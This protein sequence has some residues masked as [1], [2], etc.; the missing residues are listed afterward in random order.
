MPRRV[1]SLVTVSLLLVGLLGF[2]V[3]AQAKESAPSPAPAVSEPAQAGT[4]GAEDK[5]EAAKGPD[6][7]QVEEQVGEQAGEQTEEGS[8]DAAL[9]QAEPAYT[10]TV[11]VP[12]PE[13]ADLGT[14]AKITVDEA[15]AAAL[16]ANPGTTVTKVELDNENGYLVYGVE[17]SNGSDVKVDAGNGSVLHTETAGGDDGQEQTSGSE[18]GSD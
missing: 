5:A 17:L 3:V 18:A 1:L 9:D 8:A 15:Q 11:S 6:T 7:D 14:L 13:P 10:G 4:G 12:D 16:A 2:T